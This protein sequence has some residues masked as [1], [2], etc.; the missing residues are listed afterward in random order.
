MDD[1]R[2][3]RY[4]FPPQVDGRAECSR[5]ARVRP[6]H[7]LVGNVS[8]LNGDVSRGDNLGSLI[9]I[10][11][12]PVASWQELH[13]AVNLLKALE[14]LALSFALIASSRSSAA[15]VIIVMFDEGLFG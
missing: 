7:H 13:A 8:L 11:L 14:N 6:N 9:F 3:A 1:A 4:S 10:K 15:G 12:K 5:L 2:L